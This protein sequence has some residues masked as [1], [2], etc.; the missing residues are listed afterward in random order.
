MPLPGPRR[1]EFFP[2]GRSWA[3]GRVPVTRLEP[4]PNSLELIPMHSDQIH[5]LA[6]VA[7]ALSTFLLGG[8]WYSPLLFGRAWMK[9]N[10]FTDE[11]LRGRNL[12]RTFGG[13]AVL[14]LVM[15]TNLASFWPTRRPPVAWGV[16]AGLLAG[17]GWVGMAIGTI[18]L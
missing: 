8:L 9:T 2:I 12:A 11:H 15:A 17:A 10:G 7:A 6:I 13:A 5:V 1:G 16:A 18:A 14:A 4:L 3:L